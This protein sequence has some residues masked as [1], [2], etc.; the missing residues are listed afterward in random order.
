MT[1]TEAIPKQRIAVAAGDTPAWFDH[2]LATLAADICR[3]A[4]P[5]RREGLQAR[6]DEMI[7]QRGQ[8]RQAA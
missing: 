5:Q 6:M 2:A 8:F 1:S 3:E 4:T 7:R